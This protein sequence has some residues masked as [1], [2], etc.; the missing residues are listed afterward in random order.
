M[1]PPLPTAAFAG[2]SD[3]IAVE[4]RL[5]VEPAGWA[6][7]VALVFTPVEAAACWVAALVAV[8]DFDEPPHPASPTT[9]ATAL[10]TVAAMRRRPGRLVNA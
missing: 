7:V 9:S 6:L 4:Y 2:F 5:L 10:T 8:V 1:C 3:P